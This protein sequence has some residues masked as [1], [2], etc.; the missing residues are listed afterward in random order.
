MK[1]ISKSECPG[2]GS[3]NTPKAGPTVVERKEVQRRRCKD[4]HLI[5][6]TA[7]PYIRKANLTGGQLGRGK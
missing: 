1:N 4:C 2:C 5:Y 3:Y 7:E 6:T